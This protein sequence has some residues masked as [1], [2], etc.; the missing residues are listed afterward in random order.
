[1]PPTISSLTILTSNYGFPHF[2]AIT[3]GNYIP[4]GSTTN[5]FIKASILSLV[6]VLAATVTQAAE[7]QWYTTRSCAG[8]S[9]IDD[10][11]IGC[12][13]CVDPVGGMF[14]LTHALGMSVF[15]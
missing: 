6:A 4:Q 10:R 8:G 15:H 12:N 11:D 1:M 7:V 3:D 5:M 2:F 14:P 9:S 13:V